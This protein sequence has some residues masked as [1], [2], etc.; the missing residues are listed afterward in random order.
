MIWIKIIHKKRNPRD[1]IA[2]P[3]AHKD[4]PCYCIGQYNNKL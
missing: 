4:D 1:S 3:T 2:S